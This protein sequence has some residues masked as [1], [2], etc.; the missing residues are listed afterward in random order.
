MLRDTLKLD[1]ANVKALWVRSQPKVLPLLDFEGL[2][3]GGHMNRRV[4]CLKIGGNTT[5][6]VTIKCIDSENIERFGTFFVFCIKVIF[7][8]YK[9]YC[10]F[11][12][13]PSQ[14]QFWAFVFSV[15]SF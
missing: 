9:I 1:A 12:I 13:R 15:L 6:Y 3:P 2:S 14:H 4:F 11:K 7:E 10:V 5:E 8:I